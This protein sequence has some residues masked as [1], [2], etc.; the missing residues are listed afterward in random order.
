MWESHTTKATSS[1]VIHPIP[2]GDFCINTIRAKPCK[3]VRLLLLSNPCFVVRMLI[4]NEFMEVAKHCSTINYKT[5][6]IMLLVQASLNLQCISH[7]M[8]SGCISVTRVLIKLP[9]VYVIM[10]C[11]EERQINLSAR[12]SPKILVRSAMPH[13]HNNWANVFCTSPPRQAD[14][15]QWLPGY[16]LESKMWT[17]VH[18]IFC[19]NVTCAYAWRWPAIAPERDASMREAPGI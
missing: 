18:S 4:N 7:D 3:F 15:F 6:I 5:L 13:L 2:L 9:G 17:I 19:R 11:L 14:G 8:A 1:D 10:S 16:L 12:F